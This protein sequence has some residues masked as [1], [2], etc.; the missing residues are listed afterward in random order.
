[1]SVTGVVT[2][3]GRGNKINGAAAAAGIKFRL[4]QG[5]CGIL[6][7]S[8]SPRTALASTLKIASPRRAIFSTLRNTISNGRA[9][10]P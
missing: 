10:L 8:L 4:T 5:K 9:Q 3:R 1:M 7:T 2:I 6:L